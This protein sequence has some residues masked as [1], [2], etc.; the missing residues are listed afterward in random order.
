MRRKEGGDKDSAALFALGTSRKAAQG[1]EA[2]MSRASGDGK[3]PRVQ[4]ISFYTSSLA[5]LNSVSC[6]MICE[7]M[8]YG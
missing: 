3:Q 5:S 8:R 6:P 1:S 4:T 2:N 7:H